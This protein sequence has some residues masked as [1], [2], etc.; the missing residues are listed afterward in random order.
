M[1]IIEREY[2]LGAV[3]NSAGHPILWYYLP[4]PICHRMNNANPRN[5]YYLTQFVHIITGRKNLSEF[6]HHNR[7]S[8]VM[9]VIMK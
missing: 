9:L 2:W 1:F 5:A 3:L 4:L 6:L 7:K 8:P